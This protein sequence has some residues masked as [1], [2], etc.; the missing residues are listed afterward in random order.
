MNRKPREALNPANSK[1]IGLLSNAYFYDA[2]CI[3]SDNVQRSAL[4]NFIAAEQTPRW[5]DKC[6]SLRNRVVAWFGLKNLGNF[7]SS[8]L[9]R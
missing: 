7:L 4:E 2:W 5:V 6:M 1:I 3:E 8:R 9:K